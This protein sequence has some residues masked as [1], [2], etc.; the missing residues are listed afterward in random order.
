MP[1]NDTEIAPK[2]PVTNASLKA[3]IYP[4]APFIVQSFVGLLSLAISYAVPSDFRHQR[5]R[6]F[7]TARDLRKIAFCD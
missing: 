1:A 7:G 5:H 2:T 4:P 6:F 3:R